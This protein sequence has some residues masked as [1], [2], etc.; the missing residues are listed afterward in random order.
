MPFTTLTPAA[1]ARR[2]FVFGM[3]ALLIGP[4]SAFAVSP[5][6]YFG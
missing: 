6:A 2:A 3:T 4:A 5:P 1:W